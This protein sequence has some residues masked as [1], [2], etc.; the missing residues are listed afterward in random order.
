M[1]LGYWL[2]DWWYERRRRKDLEILWPLLKERSKS[3]AAAKVAFARH[4]HDDAA[5]QHLGSEHVDRIVASRRCASAS[6][7]CPSS[8]ARRSIH[9]GVRGVDPVITEAG[10]AE[11]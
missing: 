9:C 2:Q 8:S 7:A 1:K 5:W 3:L 11:A 6:S 10:W 4:V